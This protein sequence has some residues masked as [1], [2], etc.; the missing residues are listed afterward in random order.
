MFLARW[1]RTDSEV[2]LNAWWEACTAQLERN[3]SDKSHFKV[4]M[5]SHYHGGNLDLVRRSR[6]S[7]LLLDLLS[8]LS[9]LKN[10]AWWNGCGQL[11]LSRRTSFS[12]VVCIMA[13]NQQMVP[14]LSADWLWVLWGISSP[15]H[16]SALLHTKVEVCACGAFQ[17][18]RLFGKCS[19]RGR[20]DMQVY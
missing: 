10:K 5:K 7:F 19:I 8:N 14:F 1:E 18:G 6:Y 12:S 15:L 4:F 20:G 17:Q 11:G 9:P 2:R 13:V 3:I 16:A